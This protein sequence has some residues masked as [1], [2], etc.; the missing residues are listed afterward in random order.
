MYNC[1]LLMLQLVRGRPRRGAQRLEVQRLLPQEEDS[2]LLEGCLD[3][4]QTHQRPGHLELSGHLG[5]AQV[6]DVVVVLID[7]ASHPLHG[8]RGP[9]DHVT[10]QGLL[11]QFG[12]R[13]SQRY[14]LRLERRQRTG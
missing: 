7:P 6:A 13:R 2:L 10:D 4:R 3:L 11:V 5:H 8:L 9:S 12:E 1:Y 14:H